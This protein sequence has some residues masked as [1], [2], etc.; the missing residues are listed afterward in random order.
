MLFA[1]QLY[2]LSEMKGDY[3]ECIE[4]APDT[5]GFEREVGHLDN[6]RITLFGVPYGQI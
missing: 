2:N 5:M 6:R 3:P 1:M 4:T